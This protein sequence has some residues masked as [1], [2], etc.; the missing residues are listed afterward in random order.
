MMD[1]SSKFHLSPGFDGYVAATE[2][3]TTDGT[4]HEATTLS[5]LKSN[6]SL[7]ILR[8]ASAAI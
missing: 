1:W 7:L 4:D 5:V 3:D 6:G 8:E 2:S